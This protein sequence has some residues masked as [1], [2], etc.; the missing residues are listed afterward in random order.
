M[1][2]GLRAVADMDGDYPKGEVLPGD[3]VPAGLLHNRSQLLLI[4]P[5]LNR[6]GEID[7]GLWVGGDLLGDNWE[8]A[9]QVAHVYKAQERVGWV[10]KFGDHDL[11]A[12]LGDP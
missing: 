1:K 8:G 4:W 11:A 5:G 2:S 12:D 6:F 10:A 3:L 7:I 9:H